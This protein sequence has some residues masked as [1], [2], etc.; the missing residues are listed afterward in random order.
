MRPVSQRWVALSTL[1]LVFPTVYFISISALKFNLGI[2]GPYDS[3]WPLLVRLGI[4]ESIGININLLILFGPL[5]AILI[6]IFQVLT[7]DKRFTRDHFHFH[8]RI[9]KRWFPI[10]VVAFCALVMACLLLYLFAEN[11]LMG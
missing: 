10:V 2:N 8:F 5:L 4:T 11:C 7:I 1:L 9:R 3:S 6:N